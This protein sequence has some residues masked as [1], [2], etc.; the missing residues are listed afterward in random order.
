[1]K[2]QQTGLRMPVRT[3]LLMEPQMVR[4]TVRRKALQTAM[5]KHW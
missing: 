4:L 1:M 2:A 3:A 5:P